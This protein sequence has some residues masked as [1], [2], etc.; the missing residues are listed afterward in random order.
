ME[1]V[2]RLAAMVRGD[3]KKS[4]DTLSH[5]MAAYSLNEILRM[6][7]RKRGANLETQA[8]AQNLQLVIA[9]ALDTRS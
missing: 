5:N 8:H 1:Y 3:K 7:K 4:Y 9:W 2:N 6:Q